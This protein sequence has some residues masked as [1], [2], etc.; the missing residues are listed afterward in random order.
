MILPEGRYS[1]SGVNPEDAAGF[2]EY[3]TKLKDGTMVSHSNRK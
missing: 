1:M 2:N 3:E